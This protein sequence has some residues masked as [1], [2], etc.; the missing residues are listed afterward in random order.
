MS[1][2]VAYFVKKIK[3]ALNDNDYIEAKMYFD[4][5]NLYVGDCKEITDFKQ[6][7]DKGLEK[8]IL[9]KSKTEE[10]EIKKRKPINENIIII[11]VIVVA[12]VGFCIYYFGF[13]SPVNRLKRDLSDTW[14]QGETRGFS[15]DVTLAFY[16]DR[17]GKCFIKY[18]NRLGGSVELECEVLS[19]SKIL[20]NDR[21]ISVEIDGD[22]LT[23]YPA[24][25]GLAEKSVWR[26]DPTIYGEDKTGD[27]GS[28]VKDTSQ[29]NNSSNLSTTAT[30][31]DCSNG[32]DFVDVTEVVKHDEVG[33]YDDVT[34]REGTSDQYQCCYC[35][36]DYAKSYAQ[37]SAH[38]NSVHGITSKDHILQCCNVIYGEDPVVER[39]WVVDKEAYTETI[40]TGQ[41]CSR[42]GMVKE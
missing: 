30:K 15:A 5:A 25:I 33:H 24:I 2:K 32:H 36:G 13:V 8:A 19:G 40:V 29:D 28:T 17:D 31:M 18:N 39:K 12:L 37:I 23:F 6:I 38:F 16:E 9:T 4:K 21:E 7:I 42:C 20:V 34:V 22:Y 35:L 41:K 10:T 14:Y 1:N 26:N 27:F 11:P 3:Y